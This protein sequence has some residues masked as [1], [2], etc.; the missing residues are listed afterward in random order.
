MEINKPISTI[1]LLIITLILVFLFALPK[2][3]E[4]GDL[5]KKLAEKQA[6][7]AGR[8]AYFDNIA[9]LASEIEKRKSSLEKIGSAL[10]EDIS[11]SQITY[12][13]Q[14][15]AVQNGIIVKSVAFSRLEKLSPKAASD[16]GKNEIRE[17]SFSAD[18]AGSYQGF[19]SFLSATEKSSRLFQI[20][21]ISFAPVE[22]FQK[23]TETKNP[24]P[25]YNFKM[26]IAAYAR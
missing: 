13:I 11:L 7:Y 18:L 6:E 22:Q 14:D 10:P 2:Y 16:S 1:T 26:E 8:A 23:G 3:R 15:N 5:E 19:K 17:I 25:L 21:T 12:F 24:I 9:K 20:K 4:A